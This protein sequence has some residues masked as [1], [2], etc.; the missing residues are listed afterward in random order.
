MIP[1]LIL[2]VSMVG[3]VLSSTEE[4]TQHVVGELTKQFPVYQRQ[5]TRTLIR[6]V[7][8]RTASG[9]LGTVVLVA[10]STRSE[11]HTSELQSRPHLVCRLLLEKTKEAVLSVLA[12]EGVSY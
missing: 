2:C 8:A 12:L 3:F 11:E 10:F 4:A 1:I 9:V 6:I 7:E 5:I